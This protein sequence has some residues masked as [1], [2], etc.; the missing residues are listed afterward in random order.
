VTF[1]PDETTT[2]VGSLNTSLAPSTVVSGDTDVGYTL[3]GTAKYQVNPWLT[4][5]GSAGAYRTVTL[6]AG[7]IDWGYSAGAGLDLASSRHVVWSADYLFT[8][9]DS[10]INGRNDTH[11]VTVGVTVKK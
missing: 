3:S 4:L 6:A 11:A 2:L 10:S 5:R 8:H 7:A 9:D 1:T